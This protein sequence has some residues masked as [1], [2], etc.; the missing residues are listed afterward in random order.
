MAAE[1]G[2][3]DLELPQRPDYPDV[4]ELAGRAARGMS[5]PEQPVAGLRA[6]RRQ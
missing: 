6:E 4:S 5:E 2:F 1:V 3:Q